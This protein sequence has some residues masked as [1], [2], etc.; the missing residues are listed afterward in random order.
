MKVHDIKTVLGNPENA[1]NLGISATV[2]RFASTLFC[3][4][5]LGLECDRILRGREVS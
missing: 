1:D 2:L 3:H 5:Y 4:L